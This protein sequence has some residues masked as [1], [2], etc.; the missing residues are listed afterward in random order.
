[1]TASEDDRPR[2]APKNTAPHA[3]AAKGAPAAATDVV[4][5][6]SGHNGLVAAA[7][8]ARY[9]TRVTV[10]E[11]LDRIGGAAV[12]E[13]PFPGIDAS[14]SRYSYLVSL[15]PYAIVRDLELDVELRSRPVASYT[16]VLR[17]GKPDGLLVERRPGPR[18]AQSF[19]RLTGSDR[20]W[21]AWQEFYG[22]IERAARV[23]APSLLEPLVPKGEMMKAVREAVGGAFWDRFME[24]PLGEVVEQTFADD[25]VRGVVLTDALIGTQSHAHDPSL[26]Q[27][28]CFLYHVIGNGTG[29]WRVP[30][31]GMGAVAQSLARAADK[32]GAHFVTGATVT[33]IEAD[34]RRASVRYTTADGEKRIDARY[35]LVN[36]APA[37]LDELL[38]RPGGRR[39]EGNQ[40]KINMVLS[41]LPALR[42]GMDPTLAFAGTLHVDESYSGLLGAYTQ[43]EAGVLPDPLPAEVYCHTLTDRTIL[44]PESMK[45]GLQTLT[46][47]GLHTPARL[48]EA[49]GARDEA[50]R[51]ALA[52]LNRHLA[53]PIEDCLALD[54]EGRPCLE[55]RSPLDIERELAMPGGHIFHGD[56][57]WPWAAHDR[58]VG[59]WGVETDIP[60]VLICG[61]GARRG[62]A[63]SGVPGRAAALALLL[64]RSRRRRER[65]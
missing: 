34:G 17:E 9:G 22:R 55:A 11:R 56:L 20:E 23:L 33:R 10:L 42:S 43:A 35:V 52:G 8:L 37:I 65:G 48:Y 27:N 63:I 54:A 45:R 49:P 32:A 30:I 21:R 60:N 40:L 6:G 7:Y 1:M 5:V 3:A 44:G 29:E 57:D 24:Q 61:S 28:R 38:G 47:F 2:A 58:E 41:R 31:G 59:T 46:L 39:P 12:S 36:A 15:L 26:A 64:S 53:E 16:P 18:T 19:H 25:D 13:R 14:L 62:G 50:V 4:I 51:L